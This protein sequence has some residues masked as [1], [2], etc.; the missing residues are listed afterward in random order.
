M[1]LAFPVSG[2]V[3]GARVVSTIEAA[4]WQKAFTEEHRIAGSVLHGREFGT[5]N[6]PAHVAGSIRTASQKE[7]KG[8]SSPLS[9]AAASRAA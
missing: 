5:E 1:R 2:P 4:R 8:V 7:H 6:E 3:E 9:I